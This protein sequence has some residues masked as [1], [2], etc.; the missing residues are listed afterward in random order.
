MPELRV[1]QRPSKKRLPNMASGRRTTNS[2]SDEIRFGFAASSANHFEISLGELV[3][4][5]G[6]RLPRSGAMEERIF[7]RVTRV[8]TESQHC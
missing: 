8:V 6:A 7:F 4:V 1:R 5:A 2:V 3:L